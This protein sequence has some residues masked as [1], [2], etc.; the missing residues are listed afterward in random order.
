MNRLRAGLARFLWQRVMPAAVCLLLAATV[1]QASVWAFDLPAYL[2]PGPLQVAAAG[3]NKAGVLALG[4]LLTGGA[5]LAGFGLSLAVG[6]AIAV[7]FSQ[8][9]WIRRGG[10]PYAILLQ[11]VPIV[12]IAP[13]VINWFGPGWLGVIAVA[14]II[15]VFPIIANTTGG[16]LEVP[17]GCLDLFRLNRAGRRQTLCKLRFPAAVPQIVTGAKTSAGLAVVGAIVGEFF[18]GFGASRQGLGYLILQAIP[19]LRTDELF[20]QVI[21]SAL[22]GVLIFAAV[23]LVGEYVLRRWTSA[24]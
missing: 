6:V 15:S 9:Q 23:S 10:Y 4:T 16:L 8:S 5:A 12:A 17:A 2:L 11:T 20:A 24:E 1:W 21:A 3:W 7:V 18:A 22:L 13:L 14:H 19:Q